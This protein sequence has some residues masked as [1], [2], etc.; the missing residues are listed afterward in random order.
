MNPTKGES[1]PLNKSFSVAYKLYIITS[2]YFCKAW[3]NPNFSTFQV[4]IASSSS[5]IKIRCRFSHL[6]LMS[7]LTVN[8]CQYTF[9]CLLPF[10]TKDAIQTSYHVMLT[11]VLHH[12]WRVQASQVQTLWCILFLNIG[13]W[14]GMYHKKV[15]KCIDIFF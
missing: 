8:N 3:S 5:S 4:S 12:F 7:F 9:P 14:E 6:L 11:W 15:R 1:S 10:D 13:R 2:P